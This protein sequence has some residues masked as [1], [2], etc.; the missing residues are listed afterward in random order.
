MEDVVVMETICCCLKRAG[1]SDNNNKK[2]KT[3]IKIK[4]KSDCFKKK[5]LV[6]NLNDNHLNNE[7]EL[8]MLLQNI[9]KIILDNQSI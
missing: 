4:I 6:I 7:N 3:T 9:K 8:N 5:K 1:E 2:L